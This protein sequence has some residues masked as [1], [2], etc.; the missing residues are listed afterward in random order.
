[1]GVM[2]VVPSHELLEKIV[3]RGGDRSRGEELRCLRI[4]R[5]AG[6]SGAR[7]DREPRAAHHSAARKRREFRHPAADGGLDIVSAGVRSGRAVLGGRYAFRAG[8]R[9]NLWCFAVETSSTFVAQFEVLKGEAARR[10][11]IDP[12]FECVGTGGQS[13]RYYATT[14]CSVREDGRNESEI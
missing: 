5:G 12:S 8:R 7:A 3:A 4:R 10:K 2:G 14:G 11:Q 1:M 6:G 13:R 9:G